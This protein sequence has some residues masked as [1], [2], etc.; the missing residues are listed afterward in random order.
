MTFIYLSSSHKRRGKL[1]SVCDANFR[2][3][4]GK[5]PGGF[6]KKTSPAL[7]R[8]GILREKQLNQY[9]L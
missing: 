6:L 1:F 5:P 3:L 7:Q 8:R 2:K 4:P 9:V